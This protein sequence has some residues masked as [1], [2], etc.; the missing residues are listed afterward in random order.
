MIGLLYGLIC[1]NATNISRHNDPGMGVPPH[2][3]ASGLYALTSTSRVGPLDKMIQIFT[4]T[5]IIK[6]E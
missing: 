6:A 5:F 2:A 4:S 1:E 3:R